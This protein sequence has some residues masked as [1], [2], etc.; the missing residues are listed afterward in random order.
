ME[1]DL[2]KIARES[3]K[4]VD[5]HLSRSAVSAHENEDLISNHIINGETKTQSFRH[6]NQIL[7]SKLESQD[8]ESVAYEYRFIYALGIRLINKSDEAASENED[9]EPLAEMVAHFT[10]RYRCPDQLDEDVINAFAP[11][12]VCYHIWP[13]WREYVQSTCA[14]MGISPGLNVPHYFAKKDKKAAE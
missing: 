11:E 7:E 14:R 13:Y 5:V 9:F 1:A 8:G 3:L 6:V 10:A 2:Q 12:N 4:I